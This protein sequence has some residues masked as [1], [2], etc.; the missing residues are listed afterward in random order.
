MSRKDSDSQT[1][2]TGSGDV[3][4]ND[5]TSQ[6]VMGEG[7][8]TIRDVIQAVI[9]GQVTGDVHIGDKVYTHSSL[10]ELDDYLARAVADYRAQ[11]YQRMYQASRRQTSADHPY[12]FLNA[13]DLED[14][15]FFF[16][17]EAAAETL[18]QKVLSDRLTVLH[19]RSG[20]GKTSLLNAGLSPR[21]ISEGFLP[22]YTRPHDDPTEAL[23][24]RMAPPSRR[25]W[26]Q[27]LAPLSLHEF[28]GLVCAHLSQTQEQELVVILDQFEEF[29]V[30]LPEPD[31]RQPFVNGLGECYEDESLPVRFVI[32]IRGDYF[33]DLADF[34][35]RL[36]NVFHNEH[37]LEPMTRDEASAAISQPLT[38]LSPPH[39]YEP[40]LLDVLLD[41]LTREGLE[42][43]HLQIVCT[44]LYETLGPAETLI[45]EDRYQAL[46][47]TEGILGNYLRREIEK[48]G[49]DA[50]L[51]R[52]ILTEL[53]TSENTRRALS[54]D[55]L[56]EHLFHRRDLIRLDGVLA[57]LINARLLRRE[58]IEGVVRYELVHE[59]LIG[60]IRAWVTA[61]DLR[62]KQ[63][64]ETLGR[65]LANWRAHTW[66]MDEASL[67]FVHEHRELL[68]NLNTEET[69][70]LF[71]S[72]VAHQLA[73]DI[74]ALAA[75]QKD[76]DIWPILQPALTAPAH[77][78]RAE[79]V[80]VL[81]VVGEAALPT[82]GRAL[83]DKAPLVR[84]QAIRALECLG[85]REAGRTL[86][87]NLRHEVY[88]PPDESGPG[89]YID[90]YPVTNQAYEVFLQDN[91]DHKPPA[92]WPGRTAPKYLQDHPVVGVSWKDAQAYASWAG[93]RL[94]TAAE[95]QRAAGIGDGRRYPWGNQ[96]TPGC[97]NTREAGE[98]RT[99]P[100]GKY[101][102]AADSPYGAVD[103]AG[104]VW[105]W[106]ADEAGPDGQ[107]RR[108]RGGAW[109]YSAEF[110][111]ID[112]DLFWR[113]PEDLQDV[114]GF[115]LCFSLSE[116]KEG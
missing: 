89:F 85:T 98:D 49:Q 102:P 77:R 84:V 48:L 83:A 14:S 2:I 93:K 22:V 91:P 31:L 105:E 68:S 29:F 28:L 35:R 13:F 106:L 1:N 34:E 51:A 103:M 55:E 94:P 80:A 53:I 95:W 114:I 37:R 58:E 78:V 99:T 100:V 88:I 63:A 87:A 21:L 8:S 5:G 86:K 40:A 76:I 45:R 107:Y 71:H 96:F 33:T 7:G 3:E 59:Y 9:S 44:H 39:V 6:V 24:R 90:R 23:K 97:C 66:L 20:A 52:V 67:T 43:P 92:Y 72:A 60:Q 36:P 30:F 17:R 81:P 69:E 108:L 110:T 104:N 26:P 50:P 4:D 42:P 46:G 64:R 27:L 82:L 101:S 10:E 12:K 19:A 61:E 56:R 18:Y 16:G 11:M 32:G 54:T 109:F 116:V 57:A 111:R 79:V 70:L 113:Q 65:A 112:Y 38:Y 115:R 73:V 62:A 47:R 15:R 74:W 41:D 25:P 75:H